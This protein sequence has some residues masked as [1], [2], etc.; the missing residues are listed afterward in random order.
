MKSL[1]GLLVY[2]VARE[3][4][5]AQ[6]IEVDICILYFFQELAQATNNMLRRVLFQ[7]RASTYLEMGK[8]I[9]SCPDFK[10]GSVI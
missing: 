8:A 1:F 9:A 4:R 2:D 7:N 3:N 10:P 5:T 6:T